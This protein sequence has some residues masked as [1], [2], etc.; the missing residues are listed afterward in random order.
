M[1]TVADDRNDRI[2]T[3][4]SLDLALLQGHTEQVRR[5][6]SPLDI[7]DRIDALFDGQDR[8]EILVRTGHADRSDGL[9]LQRGNTDDTGLVRGDQPDVYPAAPTSATRLAP[10]TRV[11]PVAGAFADQGWIGELSEMS[12]GKRVKVL[13][14]IMG[15]QVP[16]VMPQSA[17]EVVG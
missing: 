7:L 1:I 5:V 10:G 14:S 9:A 13:L 16:V 11:R 6:G 12:D 2:R 17:V 3:R 8:Y 4:K 15:R